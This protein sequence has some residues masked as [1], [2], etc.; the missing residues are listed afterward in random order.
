MKQDD[1]TPDLYNPEFMEEDGDYNALLGGI[2]FNFQDLNEDL[3]PPLN[4]YNGCGP[5]LR[6]GVAQYFSTPFECVGECGGMSYQFF[7]RITVN[8]NEYACQNADNNNVFG[9]DIWCNIS[10]QEMF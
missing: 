6:Q 3:T 8:S 4:L 10:V 2:S 5:K 7:K 1:I 9:G